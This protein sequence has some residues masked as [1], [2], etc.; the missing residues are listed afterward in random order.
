MQTIDEA[1][2]HRRLVGKG[3]ETM[4]LVLKDCPRAGKNLKAK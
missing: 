1:R 3:I 2:E 4:P